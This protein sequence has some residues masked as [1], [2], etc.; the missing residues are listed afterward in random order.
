MFLCFKR[1]SAQAAKIGVRP[2]KPPQLPTPSPIQLPQTAL[3]PPMFVP[4]KFR[5][6]SME[7]DMA[8]VP[9]LR[10]STN[11]LVPSVR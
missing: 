10:N 5:L 4:L 9:L 1:T 7:D 6:D 2:A 8:E 3:T 11:A